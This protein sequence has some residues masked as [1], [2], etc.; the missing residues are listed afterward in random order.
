M[1]MGTF[2][3]PECSQSQGVL[4]G[5]GPGPVTYAAAAYP[6]VVWWTLGLGMGLANALRHRVRGYRT[7]RPFSPDQVERSVDYVVDVVDRWRRQGELDLAGRRVLELGPGPDLGTGAVMLALGA[8]SYTAADL[9]PLAADTPSS[10]YDGLASRIGRPID[11][12][13][14]AY[15]VT[16]FP[17]MPGLEGPF[18][19][20]VSN[21]ALE[22]FDDVP[23]T[24][25]RLAELVP[26]GG[27]M[28]HH[29]DGMVH[30]RGIRPRDPLNLLRY[31]D[32]IYRAMSFPGVPNRLRSSDFLMAARSTGWSAR[33][34]PDLVAPASYLD[35]VR[36]GL[37]RAWR[38]KPDDDLAMLTFTLV[39]VRE[40][41]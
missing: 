26:P 30:M 20:V 8:A 12:G 9:F 28:C 18:D 17:D 25:A 7:P 22:H 4:E 16:S 11:P 5:A 14:L 39:C 6:G 40:R 23:A 19:V 3:G 34:V 32:W 10:F 33:V 21:A 35:G 41:E 29:I 36:S 27:V 37:S 2:D 13:Q 24:F 1:D 31:P 15:R 38:G